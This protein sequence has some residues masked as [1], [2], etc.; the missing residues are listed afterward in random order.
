[1][2]LFS[3][4]IPTITHAQK[5]QLTGIVKDTKGAFIP[6]VNVVL[7]NEQDFIV[8]YGR[9]NEK[10]AYVLELTDA[11]SSPKLF[12]Q[13]SSVGY[14]KMQQPFVK[15]QY[16][17]DFSMEEQDNYLSEVKITNRPSVE[18]IGDTLSFDVNSFA[19]S[20]D[21]SIGDVIKRL[22]GI[23]V[24]ENGQISFNGKQIK[25]LYIH[26]DD[27]MDGRYGLATKVIS[28][29][30][31]KSIDIMEH[32]QPIKV[33]K[34]KVFTDE[35]AINLV[36]KN[37]NSLKLGGQA[38]LGA[39]LPGQYDAALNAMVFNKKIK[40]LNS[41]KV[42]N[43]GVD[44]KD[45]FGQLGNSGFT[46][47]IANQKPENILSLGTVGNPDLPKVNYYLN[48]SNSIN[49]N[50]LINLNNGLQLKS[51]AQLFIDRNKLNYS[52]SLDNYLNGDTIRYREVQF[53]ANKNM[54]M[55][56]AFT[57]TANK[58]SYFFNNKLSLGLGGDDANGYLDFNGRGFNQHLNIRNYNLANDF[59]YTP[60]L[61]NSKNVIDFR[62]Y[63]SHFNNPQR[64]NID[65]GLNPDQINEG[66]PYAA[67]MQHLKTPT[68]FSNVTL[69]YRIFGE[70]LIQQTYQIGVVNE[71]QQLTSSIDL[72][73]LDNAVTEYR[74]DVG[75]DLQWH[76]DRAFVNAEY[77][78]KRDH[79]KAS[80]SVPLTGQSIR[81]QQNE[82]GLDVQNS[83][84]FINP[85]ANF[86][87]N[88]GEEDYLEGNYS[89]N[90]NFGNITSIY[91]GAVLANYRTIFA[92]KTDLQ[93]Q[94]LSNLR[95]G[96]NF[97][98]SIIL[99]FA[100]ARINYKRVTANTI[101]S[102]DLT[103][104][105]QRTVLLPFQNNQN[106]LSLNAE[107]SKFIFALNTTFSASSVVSRSNYNQLINNELYP[108]ENKSLILSAQ[109]ESKLFGKL[110]LSY[111]GSGFWNTS[112]QKPV[113]GTSL[114]IMSK[115]RRFNQNVNLGYSPLKNLLIDVSGRHIY[116]KQAN[117]SNINYLFTDVGTRYKV[118]KW[119]TD[120]EF[121]LSNL[122]NIKTYEIFNLSSN[123]FYVSRYEIR[124]RMA[125]L[126]ATFIL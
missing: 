95:L 6:Y 88:T 41:I 116:G 125:I 82:Y 55:N 66:N 111:N 115:T 72:V 100:S 28:K 117:I 56:A 60:A 96:Y 98:R 19:R 13:V 25:N 101:L 63:V 69:A 79:W 99:L 24:A 59:N 67:S 10:G 77:S 68:F 74:A 26:G 118:V 105:V 102:S 73:Q 70:H 17:Y 18:S 8:A 65:A 58:S 39:G 106:T 9:G 123:Q 35:V 20:E 23:I 97:K 112:E 84:L 32:F 33:L 110:T 31:I 93:E 57:A 52:N 94:E 119:H 29:E 62:W 89:F 75:N 107:I 78:I 42:N 7:K 61:A 113:S 109:I 81:Y 122:A 80:V 64:L 36:L 22:P 83:R 4:V 43:S 2:L 45:D 11:G 91:R 12:I 71:R 120:F 124:G 44:L 103:D 49:T 46:A 90:K 114:N 121:K 48:K 108:F 85:N 47:D 50:N 76:R 92:N 15:N 21:R 40:A 3:F 86:T 5:K 38:M 37:E 53:L 16:Q 87:L 104:N 27:L 14:K 30:M 51:N 1:M 126:R 54:L 34:N